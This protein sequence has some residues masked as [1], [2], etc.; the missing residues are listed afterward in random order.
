M[1]FSTPRRASALRA[2]DNEYQLLLG[3]RDQLRRTKRRETLDNYLWILDEYNA[4][5]RTAVSRADLKER[6]GG[7]LSFMSRALDMRETVRLV[8]RRIARLSIEHYVGEP[9][10][11]D[12]YKW[13]RDLIDFYS[14]A[15]SSAGGVSVFTTNYDLLPEYLFSNNQRFTDWR[16]RT[17][18]NENTCGLEFGN[19]FSGFETANLPQRVADNGSHPEAGPSWTGY[20]SPRLTLLQVHRLHGCVAWYYGPQLENAPVSFIAPLD[21]DDF[22]S[23]A[24]YYEARLCV[25]YPGKGQRIGCPPYGPAFN[26]LH[27]T[28]RVTRHIVFIGFAFEDDDVILSIFSVLKHRDKKPLI[29]IVD[30]RLTARDVVRKVTEVSGRTSLPLWVPEESDLRLE[31]TEFPESQL[32][33]KISTTD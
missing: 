17:G 4:W 31:Q 11:G 6:F 25:M 19:G 14:D 9:E 29:T 8:R 3:I 21:I 32:W 18:L 27:E 33:E 5:T 30:P 12:N 28:C 26:R 20:C 23:E 13:A 24:P 16:R 2:P 22:C 1:F 10:C 15:A 7:Q